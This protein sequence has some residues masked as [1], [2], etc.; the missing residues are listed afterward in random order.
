MADP[1]RVVVVDDHPIVR[2]ALSR[3]FNA[4]DDMIVIDKASNGVEAVQMA[5][6]LSPDIVVM[7]YE[8]PEKGG[9]QATKE[10]V[11]ANSNLV[12]IAYTMFDDGLVDRV[13]RESGAAVHVSKH[14]GNADLLAA[15]RHCADCLHGWET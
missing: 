6:T 7:D 2:E 5:A 1:L 12:V 15:I 13:M 8:M 14:G 9:A 4:Q 11:A 3:L 10:I